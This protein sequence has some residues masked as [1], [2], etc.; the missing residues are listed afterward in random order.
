MMLCKALILFLTVIQITLLQSQ[1]FTEVMFTL[2]TVEP[3]TL[4]NSV[5]TLRT[6]RLFMASKK[7][8]MAAM[9]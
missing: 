4:Q 3:Y 1:S 9:W 6:P 2:A 7:R 8:M 5:Q